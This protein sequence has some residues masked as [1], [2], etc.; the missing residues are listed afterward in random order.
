VHEDLSARHGE[1]RT[2]EAAKKQFLAGSVR[3]NYC[4]LIT[5]WGP[6]ISIHEAE[7]LQGSALK[8]PDFIVR[9]LVNLRELRSV[10][11]SFCRVLPPSE[12]LSSL[13]SFWQAL[14]N[15][16]RLCLGFTVT[17]PM[18]LDDEKKGEIGMV[19]PF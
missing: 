4:F 12:G 19:R 7:Q 14:G 11:G 5:H 13:G 9:R 8:F 2:Y 6:Q 3:L 1:V 10:A 16:P 17:V 18:R 15:R